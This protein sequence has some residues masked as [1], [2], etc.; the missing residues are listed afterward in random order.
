MACEALRYHGVDAP[1]WARA[2]DVVAQDYGIV[3]DDDRGE[4]ARSGFTLRWAYDSAGR[5]LE[6]QCIDKPF[7]VPCGV[8][9]DRINATAA[10][11][12]VS[13]GK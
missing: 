13:G 1:M 5:T 8:V 9:N 7:L 2:K 3:I 11:A 6:I 4:A 12:G 10:K